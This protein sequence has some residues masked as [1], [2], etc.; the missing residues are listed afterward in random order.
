MNA[1]H[2]ISK[3]LASRFAAVVISVGLLSACAVRTDPL[4]LEQN[5]AGARA[6][7]AAMEAAEADV[8]VAETVRRP[9]DAGPGA[10]P[11]GTVSLPAATPAARG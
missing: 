6:D 2:G 1:F 8:A 7:L 9:A 10:A 11:A 5:A 4:T 3:D